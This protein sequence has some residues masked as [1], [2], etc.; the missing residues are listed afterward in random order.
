MHVQ[1]TRILTIRRKLHH[2]LRFTMATA[3]TR[4]CAGKRFNCPALVPGAAT[5]TSLRLLFQMRPEF[6]RASLAPVSLLGSQLSSLSSLVRGFLFVGIP[7][8]WPG[9]TSERLISDV[10]TA[11]FYGSCC[12]PD[13]DDSARAEIL[14]HRF[15]GRFECC[16]CTR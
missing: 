2:C 6:H 15:R 11:C 8:I 3:P 9:W 14:L 12:R 10:R 7:G 5:L 13:D 4:S 1:S 16:G